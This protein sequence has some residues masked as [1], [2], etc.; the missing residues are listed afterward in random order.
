MKN[1][2]KKWKE[3]FLIIIIA[4]FFV[5]IGIIIYLRYNDDDV[6]TTL[7]LENNYYTAEFLFNNDYIKTANTISDFNTNTDD[8][9]MYLDGENI[10]HIKY[11]D[12]EN[13][14]NKEVEGLPQGNVTVYYSH[15][16]DN[17]FEFGGLL[18]NDF[19]YTNFC[20]DEEVS[21]FERVSTSVLEVYTSSTDKEGV[22]VVDNSNIVSN[23]IIDTTTKEMKYLSYQ[24]KVLGLYNTID[25]VK[26]YFNYVCASDSSSL[27][28][29]IMIYLTFDNKL[30]MNYDNDLVIK[31]DIG[32]D[33]VV[34]DFF[35]VLE[36][37]ED[38]KI[39]LE[40][41]TFDD[42]EDYDYMFTVYALDKNNNLYTI[43]INNNL[44]K[45]KEAA[46]AISASLE[47]V[48]TLEYIEDDSGKVTEVVI[49]YENGDYDK[50]IEKDNFDIIVSTLYDRSETK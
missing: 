23:F 25:K 9:Y 18:N 3:R 15:L 2:D 26:P 17:C 40:E 45:E 50:I 43:S 22:H 48:K 39:D 37:L 38:E 10:L 4:I 14:V 19:Y 44:I 32:E 5:I 30:V 36:I 11:K 21:N 46:I 12:K 27:C 42:L 31:N 33:L 35:G 16:S 41:I 1:L 24:D 13:E 34:I 7:E 49:T 8:L 47:K 20:L 6:N 29:D 28:E